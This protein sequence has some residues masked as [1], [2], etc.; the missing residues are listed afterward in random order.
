MFLLFVAI[1]ASAAQPST[2]EALLETWLPPLLAGNVTLEGTEAAV[3]LPIESIVTLEA[4]HAVIE[5]HRIRM[6][7]VETP[8]GDIATRPEYAN[9]SRTMRNASILFRPAAD[10][11]AYIHGW[12]PLKLQADVGGWRPKVDPT[13]E[14]YE[15]KMNAP[16]PFFFSDEPP[17]SALNL[18]AAGAT[19]GAVPSALVFFAEGELEVTSIDGNYHEQL[20]TQKERAAP[21]LL[22]SSPYRIDSYSFVT[23]EARDIAGGF[24]MDTARIAANTL[25]FHGSATFDDAT[26]LIQVADRQYPVANTRVQIHGDA[27]MASLDD[28]SPAKWIV[29]GAFTSIRFWDGRNVVDTTVRD[30]G[31]AALVTLA[32]LAITRVGREVLAT[33]L[34]RLYTRIKS[35]RVLDN[36]ER[37]E[38]YSYV[39]KHPGQHLREL[40]RAMGWGWGSLHYHLGVLRKANVIDTKRAGK[41]TLVYPHVHHGDTT[42][43]RLMLRGQAA[44]VYAALAEVGATQSELAARLGLSRQLIAHHLVLLERDG[45]LIV[46]DARPKR[47]RR[48]LATPA[49]PA[50]PPAA[51]EVTPGDAR[52]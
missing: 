13:P 25:R 36:P 4:S 21:H 30:A 3:Q 50:R 37:A 6:T 16:L 44:N 22:G 7:V 15:Y 52:T 33:T 49:R 5:V 14:P 34:A 40:Q 10:A 41:H 51:T 27:T 8:A 45:L 11:R 1:N 42:E 38:L 48:K 28:R 43:H 46:E 47:Y 26:G 20:G 35:S 31:I 23:I 9:E 29:R 18:H 2:G 19:M 12:G 17:H 39:T 24:P 32:T